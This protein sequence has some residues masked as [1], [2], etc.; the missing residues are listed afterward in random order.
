MQH[1]MQYGVI[2]MK[3][4]LGRKKCGGLFIRAIIIAVF[5]VFFLI[6]ILIIK[7]NPVY[8]EHAASYVF[9]DANLILNR[10]VE[11]L[12][13]SLSAEYDDFISLQRDNNG[14]ITAIHTN[15]AAVNKFK[16]GIVGELE[17]TSLN[18]HDGYV[19]IP[20][21]SV[22]GIP[23]F[24]ASGPKLRF[25]V[26]PIGKTEIDFTSDFSDAGINQV[27]HSLYM[28]VSVTF[29][30]TNSFL[31]HDET[32]KTSVLIGETVIVGDVP[33]F[34]GNGGIYKGDIN[35]D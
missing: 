18:M 19:Y 11:E 14:K 35:N 3:L 9:S 4:N 13:N 28:D 6:G 33:E 8:L 34:Y 12:C 31:T 22:L 1:N 17:N 25:K 2:C 16:S 29:S 10:R 26:Y 15:T 20:F 32:V 24:S 21:G 27:C 5:A 7:L 30:I 23:V